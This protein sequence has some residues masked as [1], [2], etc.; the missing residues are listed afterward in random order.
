M[1]Q[2]AFNAGS[3]AILQLYVV[4]GNEIVG[5]FPSNFITSKHQ[6]TEVAKK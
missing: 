2:Q 4:L 1:Q 5:C 3:T 6:T